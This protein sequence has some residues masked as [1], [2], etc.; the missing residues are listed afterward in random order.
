MSDSEHSNPFLQPDWLGLQQQYLDAFTSFAGGQAAPGPDQE[1][2]TIWQQAVDHWGDGVEKSLPDGNQAVFRAMKQQHRLYCFL[3][4]QL[5]AMLHDFAG[6]GE[7]LPDWRS[8]ME[9]RFACLKEEIDRWVQAATDKQIPE[10]PEFLSAAIWQP[11]QFLFP[12]SSQESVAK[13]L[14]F[15]GLGAMKPLQDKFGQG[16]RLWK[17]YEKNRREFLQALAET[18]K[19]ALDRLADRITHMAESRQ[20]ITGL[21]QFYRIWMDVNDEVFTEFAFQED[22]ARLYANLVNSM[23]ACRQ[24]QNAVLDEIM[25]AVNLPAGGDVDTAYRRLQE[26][27]KELDAMHEMQR[28][29]VEELAKLGS[30]VQH[31][32]TRPAVKSGSVDKNRSAARKKSK[33]KQAATKKPSSD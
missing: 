29:T 8:A 5:A 6:D 14:N 18:G 22:Y 7:D 17:E 23:I 11:M 2:L 4:G 10:M 28:R 20:K 3:S 1:F 12:V 24:H 15:P 19:L 25:Q 32:E 27:R 13:L 16:I 21:G 30:A 9:S 26:M 31:L 33:T